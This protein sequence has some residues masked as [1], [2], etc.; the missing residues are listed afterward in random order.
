[1]GN[2]RLNCCD[3]RVSLPSGIGYVWSKIARRRGGL[4]P[5]PSA[6]PY[7]RSMSTSS[8]CWQ[9]WVSFS[10]AT[11]A[12]TKRWRAR[13]GPPRRGEVLGADPAAGAGPLDL[14]PLALP[15]EVVAQIEAC[16]RNARWQLYHRDLRVQAECR[17]ALRG[18]RAKGPQTAVVRARSGDHPRLGIQFAAPLT[19][20]TRDGWNT[21]TKASRGDK[22]S[23]CCRR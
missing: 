6:C 17:A 8:A 14:V 23:S 3:P 22:P 10:N 7:S 15:A 12:A 11:S 5:G 21:R 18:A 9:V 1:L 4:R 20:D 16:L 19:D 13:A 2:P